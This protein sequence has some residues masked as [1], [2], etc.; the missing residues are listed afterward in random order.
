MKIKSQYL[1]QRMPSKER[2]LLMLLCEAMDQLKQ[3]CTLSGQ[4]ASDKQAYKNTTTYYSMSFITKHHLHSN[5][6][7]D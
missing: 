3:T 5:K 4:R 6:L 1:Q 2:K 7:N